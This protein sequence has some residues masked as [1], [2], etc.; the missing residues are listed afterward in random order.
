MIKLLKKNNIARIILNNPEKHN[1]FDEHLI[2]KLIDTLDTLACD[3]TVRVVILSAEGKSFS[4]GADLNWMKKMGAYSEQENRTDAMQLARL[5][6]KLNNLNKPTIALVQGNAFGGALGLIA[7]CDIA[8]STSDAFFCF[9]E[10]KLGLIPAVISPYVLVA[11][12]ERM[13]RR[14]FL[15]AERFTAQEA[16]NIQ[17]IHQLSESPESLLND[18]LKL[19]EH[20]ANNAPDA[21]TQIKALTLS[22]SQQPID[23]IIIEKT[24]QSIAQA[25]VSS[26]GQEGL[27]AFFEKRSPIWL[28]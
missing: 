20:I 3:K 14:Y 12:G 17:L 16:H 4:A 28:D 19:A 6:Q 10:V 13:A 18:G 24:A 25:R 9:S 1:A 22:I 27:K 15:T 5:M 2:Q 8:L 23:E 21:L 26:E 11:I 7:C